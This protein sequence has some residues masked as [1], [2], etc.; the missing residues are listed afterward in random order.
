M[1]LKT[2]SWLCGLLGF[3]LLI[4]GLA[5]WNVPLACVV[6]GLLLVAYAYL[7]DRVA[8]AVQAQRLAQET[9]SQEG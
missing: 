9:P 2:M 6:A 4:V 3:V 7:L 5:L 8:T 1:N